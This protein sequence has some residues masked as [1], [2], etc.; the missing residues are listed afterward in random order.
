MRCQQWKLPQFPQTIGFTC[1]KT[2]QG[3]LNH[4]GHLMVIPWIYS[5]RTRSAPPYKYPNFFSETSYSITTL[6]QVL[7]S[8]LTVKQTFLNKMPSSELWNSLIV[9]RRY[10]RWSIIPWSVN[11][12]TSTGKKRVINLKKLTQ[13]VRSLSKWEKV[14]I[15][16]YEL[17]EKHQW[18]I[19]D[20]IYH[21]VTA[22]PIKA[23][24][25]SC[26]AR[27]KTLLNEI[28]Q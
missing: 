7:I 19:K 8:C 10:A 22:E 5:L 12:T 17:N 27:V 21:L 9:L 25:I 4:F 6:N 3:A 1:A 24:D 2:H 11:A 16:L 15:M 28:Y 20:L 13:Y 23:Y 26:L 18:S 14:N